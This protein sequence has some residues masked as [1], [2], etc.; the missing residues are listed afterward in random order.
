MQ[1]D[2]INGLA[3]KC[4]DNLV[5]QIKFDVFW[6]FVFVKDMAHCFNYCLLMFLDIFIFVDV[7]TFTARLRLSMWLLAVS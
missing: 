5:V 7:P 3:M 2:V 4:L 6:D 1:I